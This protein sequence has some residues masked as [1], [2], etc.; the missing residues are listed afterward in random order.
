[1]A[2][3]FADPAKVAMAKEIIGFP[4]YRI[5]EVGDIFSNFRAIGLGQWKQLKP[6]RLKSG[7]LQVALRSPCGRKLAYVHQLVLLNFVGHRPPNHESCHNDGDESNNHFSNLRWDTHAA[8]M[9]DKII[10]GTSGRKNP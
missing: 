2:E 6:K 8:N 9:R 10:H 1:M 5:N 4:G 3:R 7:H